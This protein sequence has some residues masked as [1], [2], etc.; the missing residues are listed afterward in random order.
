MSENEFKAVMELLIPR[1]IKSVADNQILNE[2]EALK[3]LY[4]SKLFEQLEK[5]ETKLWHLSVPMLSELL[6]EE[7]ETGHITYPEEA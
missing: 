7:Q 5:E 4:S 2:E 3:L 6:R 1:L